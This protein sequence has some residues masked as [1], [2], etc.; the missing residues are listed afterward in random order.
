MAHTM[1][2][3]RHPTGA[4][5]LKC[6]ECSYH[7]VVKLNP[8]RT[9]TLDWG[10]D[11]EHVSSVTGLADDLLKLDTGAKGKHSSLADQLFKGK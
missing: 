7:Y 1:N 2:I 3:T 10:A 8:L 9:I 5:E 4:Y 6:P 11:E